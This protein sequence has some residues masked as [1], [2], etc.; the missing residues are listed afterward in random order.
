M[1]DAAGI[2][3]AEARAST[4]IG[5]WLNFS[6]REDEGGLLYALAFDERHLGNPGIRAIHGGVVSAFLEFA[7]EAELVAVLV[8]AKLTTATCA[9]DFLASTSASEMR[10]RAKIIRLG[11]RVAFMEA[12]AWQESA[13][14]PVASAR[15]CFKIVRN[16]EKSSPAP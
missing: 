16:E 14:R 7:A 11:R 9:V 13:E 2:A 12:T 3:R 10:A 5:R 8:G 4:P 1:I 6:V 15:I